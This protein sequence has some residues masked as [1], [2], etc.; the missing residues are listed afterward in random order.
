MGANS[1][2]WSVFYM[3]GVVESLRSH[4]SAF[5]PSCLLSSF[6]IPSF[7]G[8]D[9]SVYGHHPVRGEAFLFSFF[10]FG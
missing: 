2:Y 4:A 10:F 9:R 5:R 7:F 3:G 6:V 8:G 1:G